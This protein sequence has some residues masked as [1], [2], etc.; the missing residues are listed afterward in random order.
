MQ[1]LFQLG[2]ICYDKKGPDMNKNVRDIVTI[3]HKTYSRI[4]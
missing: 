2:R 4:E 1:K 3:S